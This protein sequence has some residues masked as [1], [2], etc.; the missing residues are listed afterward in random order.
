MLA[1]FKLENMD[2]L[3]VSWTTLLII[4]TALLTSYLLLKAHLATRRPKN[5]PPGPPT[6][7]FLG[8]LP[9]IPLEKSYLT[10]SKWTA[11]YGPILGLKAGPLN[12]IIL[13]DPKDVHELFDKRGQ[14]YAG[15]PYNYIALNHI[16]EPDI[17][18]ILLFQRNDRLLKRW[19]RPARWFLSPQGIDVSLPILNAMSARC[20]QA[21]LD[22]PSKWTEHLRI[23]ALGTPI[24]AL[25]G[26]SDINPDVLRTYFYRQNILTGLL[27]PGKTPPVDFIVPLRWV[28]A[29][30][31]RWKRDARF[32]RA[33]Q[34][35]FYGEMVSAAVSLWQRRKASPPSS[36]GKKGYDS[37]MGRL[38]EEG[39]GEREVKWLAGGL[40]DAAFDTVSAG[41]MNFVVAMAAH[42]ECLRLAREEVERE[43]EGRVPQGRDV[44]RLVY[45]KACMMETFR[46]R[47]PAPLGLPH[48]TD[49]DDVYK[50]YLIPRGTNILVNA[51]GMLHDPSTHPSPGTFNPTRYLTPS[52]CTDDTLRST[53]IFGA[54]RRKCLG[55]VYTMQA[56]MTVLA[57]MV[58][59]LE[60]SVAEGTDLSV[61]GGFDGGLMLKPREEVRV[62]FGVREGR[63]E[64]V[65]RDW[66][67]GE[68]GLKVF[69]DGD[70]EG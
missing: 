53:W 1:A 44:G 27:E 54:G 25:S 21:I 17:G 47:P 68:R 55:D 58:W 65:R 9:S 18:Q 42:P 51:Y 70:I 52:S 19:K 2:V 62:E 49:S 34:D 48:V 22:D 36:G 38:L 35:A 60:M 12:L 13:Q 37:V 7:P 14:K 45:L 5:F 16:Y 33:H 64:V 31:A 20:V 32:V 26:Q 3:H 63:G 67:E 11:Q 15:R 57:K 56:L 10:F 28:P 41:V 66:E 23:W 59:G 39:M 24:V 46:W 30:F 4:T 40:L 61:E 69:L 29:W 8:N 50:G 43:C 6:T